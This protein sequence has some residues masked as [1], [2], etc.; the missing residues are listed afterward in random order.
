MVRD[1][2][3]AMLEDFKTAINDQRDTTLRAAVDALVSAALKHHLNNPDL[4]RYLEK[5]EDELPLDEETQALKNTM[6]ELIT[7]VLQQHAIP[8]PELTAFDL[9]ALSQGI[10]HAATQCGQTDYEDLR[11]RVMRAVM[12]YLENVPEAQSER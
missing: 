2:R 6:S 12:G 1:M 3:S 11:M 5:A 7:D 4:T 9:I 10:T 8:N